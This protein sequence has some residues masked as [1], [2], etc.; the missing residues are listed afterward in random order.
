MSPM[1][2]AGGSA[3]RRPPTPPPGDGARETALAREPSRVRRLLRL[4]GPGLIAG[5]AD[6]DPAG[7]STFT[8]IGAALGYA[9]LWTL[10]I[11]IP[12]MAAVQYMSAKIGLVT[13]LGLASVLRKH[14]PPILCHVLLAGL[15]IANSI[16]AGADL[17]A[18]A[19][20]LN[21]LFPRL[22]ITL[23]IFP[24]AAAIVA[25]QTW[26][27]YRLIE[28]TFKWL[29]LTL[30]AYVIAAILAKPPLPSV[31]RYT[32]LPVFRFDRPFLMGL[33]A[34]IG[35]TFSPYLYFWQANQE[36]EEKMAIGQRRLYQ[37]RGTSD[38]EL[39]Y[40]AWDVNLGMVA[41]NVV[42]YSILLASAA[43]LFEAGRHNVQ[44]A[45]QLAVALRPVAGNAATVLL[46]AGLIGTGMLAVPILTTSA[47]YAVAETF[48]WK[49]GLD[50]APTHAKEFYAVILLSTLTGVALNFLGV[51][52]VS[53][54]YWTSVIYGFM[55]PPLL[56]VIVLIT[57]NRK[58]MNSHVNGPIANL[59][60][61]ITVIASAAAVLGILLAQ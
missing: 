1:V 8:S 34:T 43:T 52:P 3:A 35:A 58:I 49:H 13:G 11:T 17:G 23:L 18:M 27:N 57:S 60:G 29:T 31:L 48:G 21:L 42:T 53:A 36:V 32:F 30:F 19:A 25:L 2:P 24:I 44:T 55:T 5:A 38:A 61:W 15:V 20:G 40:A 39:T 22:P 45:D 46:A 4:L 16:N 14:Y 26:G 28:R 10:V 47:A 54:L 12:L 41:S 50:Q 51:G 7:I 9:T 56:A 59:L 33:V 37:R 6:D